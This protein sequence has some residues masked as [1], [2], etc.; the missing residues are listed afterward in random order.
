MPQS[1]TNLPENSKQ[2]KQT[3]SIERKTGKKKP[4]NPFLS[5]TPKSGLGAINWEQ[6]IHL[7]DEQRNQTV[8]MRIFIFRG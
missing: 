4:M 5:V 7:P 1:A 2:N 6:W 3:N 8:V